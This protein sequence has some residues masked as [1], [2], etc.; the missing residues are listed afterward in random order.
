M[1]NGVR[2]NEVGFVS[3]GEYCI[4]GGELPRGEH[5]VE[6]CQS[7]QRKYLKRY[8]TMG[9]NHLVLKGIAWKYL[10]DINE[11]MQCFLWKLICREDV[12]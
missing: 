7:T 2:K 3:G 9:I 6:K 12:K 4:L 11:Q 1:K 10:T 8:N 5:L